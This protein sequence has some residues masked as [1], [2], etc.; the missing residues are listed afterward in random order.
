M[1]R[2]MENFVQ[3]WLGTGR[4]RGRQEPRI[5]KQTKYL[6]VLFKANP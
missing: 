4:H 6:Y 5:G 3:F 1:L 2:R